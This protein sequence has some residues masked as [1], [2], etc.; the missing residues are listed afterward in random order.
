M[1]AHNGHLAL[2]KSQGSALPVISAIPLLP[3][4]IAASLLVCIALLAGPSPRP[5]SP[6]RLH[7]V[8]LRQSSDL[9]L[10]CTLPS[11]AAGT[12]S[13]FWQSGQP[14]LVLCSFA[15]LV[16]K[17][18]FMLPIGALSSPFDDCG[19]LPLPYSIMTTL[20]FGAELVNIGFLRRF[21]WRMGEGRGCI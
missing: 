17:G 3:V 13:L 11:A 6:P 5:A 14:M 12:R 15:L 2:C 20:S 7:A 16:E 21:G 10:S 8:H 1:A 9:L 19:K 18:L 4:F